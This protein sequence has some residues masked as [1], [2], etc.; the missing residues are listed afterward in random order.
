MLVLVESG[1]VVCFFF[2]RVG[3]TVA[4]YQSGHQYAVVV[5][6]PP[7]SITTHIV[8]HIAISGAKAK[9]RSCC[10]AHNGMEKEKRKEKDTSFF[11]TFFF[12][13]NTYVYITL[14]AERMKDTTTTTINIL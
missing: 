5:Q 1:L 9:S 3:K 11:I 10:T 14:S 8:Q 13:S 6:T 12:N 4:N 2:L 7:I